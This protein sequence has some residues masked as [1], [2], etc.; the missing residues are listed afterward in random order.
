MFR[1]ERGGDEPRQATP[2]VAALRQSQPFSQVR[3]EPETCHS[4]IQLRAA[5]ARYDKRND[6]FL[7]SIQ[8]ATIR[9]WFRFNKSVS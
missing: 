4:F 3:R 2:T 8:L 5:A 6:N 1:R 7:A 9:I